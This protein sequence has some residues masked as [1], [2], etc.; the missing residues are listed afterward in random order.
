MPTL[1]LLPCYIWWR[2]AQ[3]TKCIIRT[4]DYP[5]GVGLVWRQHTHT[6]REREYR[7]WRGRSLIAFSFVP[8]SFGGVCRAQVEEEEEE[9]KERKKHNNTRHANGAP[10]TWQEEEGGRRLERVPGCGQG[11]ARQRFIWSPTSRALLRLLPISSLFCFLR[12]HSF[13]VFRAFP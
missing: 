11:Q 13:W 6:H 2:R 12:F 10:T 8:P 9:E 1:L 3:H 4:I 5:H 7:E